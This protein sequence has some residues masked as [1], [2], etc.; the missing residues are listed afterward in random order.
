MKYL[1]L[2]ASALALSACGN[3]SGAAENNQTAEELATSDVATEKGIEINSAFI[4]PPFPGRDIAAGFFN[5]TNSGTEDRLIA[6][7]SPF[8]AS[9]EIHTHLM[10]D[11][12]MKM[13]KVDGV[14]L[15][16]GETVRFEPGSYHLMMFG[17]EVPEGTKEVSVTLTYEKADP[18]TLMMPLDLPEE[19]MGMKME[20]GMDHGS[21]H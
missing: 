6:A 1:I 2:A 18:T 4:R 13:R 9:I 16:T 17:T 19:N 5:V 8:S 14:E 21:G 20:K 7:S 11:G 12:V 15:P 10:E 3:P